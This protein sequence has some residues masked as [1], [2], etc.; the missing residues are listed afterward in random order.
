MAK[1][2]SLENLFDHFKFHIFWWTLFIIYEVSFVITVTGMKANF[3]DYLLHYIFNIAFFYIHA[4][5]VYPFIVRQ[6]YMQRIFLTLPYLM[7]ELTFYMLIMTGV[8]YLLQIMIAKH[9]VL[10]KLYFLRYTWRGI[11]FMLLSTGF[12]YLRASLENKKKI[13]LLETEHVKT[14]LQQQLLE[15]KLIRSENSWLQSQINPHFLFNTLNLIHSKIYMTAPAAADSIIMLSDIMRFSLNPLSHQGKIALHDEIEHIELFIKLNQ[16]RFDD[17]LALSFRVEGNENGLMINP[18][19]LITLVENVFKYGDLKDHTHP[20]YIHLSITGHQLDFETHNQVKR[21]KRAPGWGIGLQNVK[22]RLEA[23]Y[24]GA[25]ELR[26]EQTGES[27]CLNL[28]I[29]LQDHDQLL[30]N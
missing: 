12:Y 2:G 27:F 23:Y 3:Y 25:H 10:N 6:K 19:L 18:L 1:R 8:A 7:L 28:H 21:G 4:Y 22:E 14:M 24:P 30:Y 16:M 20:A 17:Q 5:C 29:N 15:N 26:T 11:Y 13:G 9:V